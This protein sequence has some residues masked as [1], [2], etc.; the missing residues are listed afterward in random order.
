ML[1]VIVIT[2]RLVKITIYLMQPVRMA[3]IKIVN[4]PY[5]MLVRK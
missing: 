5:Q 3:K 2:E 4:Q 1:N